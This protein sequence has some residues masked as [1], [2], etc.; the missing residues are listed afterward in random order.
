MRYWSLIGLALLSACSKEDKPKVSVPGLTLNTPAPSPIT[1]MIAGQSNAVRLTPDGQKGF[2][3][4]AHNPG[5]RYI[6]CAENGTTLAQWD[7][8]GSRFANCVNLT[9]G[10]HI[11]LILWYQGESDADPDLASA[12]ANAFDYAYRCTQLFNAMR[13]QWGTEIPIV[14][15][16]IG[17]VDTLKLPAFVNW[18]E[19]QNQQA[20]IFLPHTYMVVTKD[21]NPAYLNPDGIHWDSPG[22]YEVGARMERAYEGGVHE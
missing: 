17:I 16:Q 22:V 20:T 10:Q 1:V 15:A 19:V 6:N 3:D 21:I 18:A 14:F 4:A 7:P 2:E 13:T 9:Q 8:R 5:N 11:D 12:G